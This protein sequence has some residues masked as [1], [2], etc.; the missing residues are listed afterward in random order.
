MVETPAVAVFGRVKN[1]EHFV[2][3]DVLDNE[4]RHF[5]IVQ[6]AAH[7]DGFVRRIVMTEDAVSFSRRP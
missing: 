1:M 4:L 5:F 7:D 3:N 6:R 2:K